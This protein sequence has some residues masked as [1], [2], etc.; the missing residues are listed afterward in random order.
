MFFTFYNVIY[1]NLYL[2]LRNL[3]LF[4]VMYNKFYCCIFSFFFL[5]RYFITFF[6]VTANETANITV[7]SQ[8]SFIYVGIFQLCA[9]LLVLWLSVY[10]CIH[11]HGLY[12]VLLKIVRC[13]SSGRYQC[14]E[15]DSILS[16]VF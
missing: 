9:T 10:L 6:V 14:A 13:Y 7:L 11:V 15:C 8:P 2:F 12:Q 5:T 3:L 4:Y 16:P 1:S